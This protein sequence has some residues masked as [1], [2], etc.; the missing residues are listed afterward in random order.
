MYKSSEI[1]KKF[2][3][4][5]KESNE[6]KNPFFTQQQKHK[7]IADLT[8]FYFFFLLL[9][10]DMANLL[11]SSRYCVRNRR[12]AIFLREE[13][14]KFRVIPMEFHDKHVLHYNNKSQAQCISL[15][16]DL[17]LVY[18]AN[19][20]FNVHSS[21]NESPNNRSPFVLNQNTVRSQSPKSHHL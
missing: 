15:A 8:D 21:S 2:E 17:L 13:G 7:R 14:I 16:A 4:S 12:A 19:Y 5:K 6:Q 1:K 9:G 3:K 18:C 20:W 11:E 10:A